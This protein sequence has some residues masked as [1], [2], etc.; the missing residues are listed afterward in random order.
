M[1]SSWPC[2]V[3]WQVAHLRQAHLRSGDLLARGGGE[4]FLILAPATDLAAARQLAE[5]LQR[6]IA[7]HRFAHSGAITVSIG[8]TQWNK[9]QTV[10]LLLS[11][12]D[13]GLYAAKQAGRNQSG[14]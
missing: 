4:E 1:P 14:G 12:A 11:Q 5:Q 10:E 2:G 8:S 3:G 6:Q 9:R 7:D 13:T